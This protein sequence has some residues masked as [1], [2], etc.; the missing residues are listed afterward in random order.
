MAHTCAQVIMW[1]LG[2]SNVLLIPK[3]VMVLSCGV[4]GNGGD[5]LY[6]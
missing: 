5:V 3:A 1:Q 2:T 6:S 4:I